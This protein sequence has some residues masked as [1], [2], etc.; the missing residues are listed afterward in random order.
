[1]NLEYA[2]VGHTIVCDPCH[3]SFFYTFI[4]PLNYYKKDKKHLN[5]QKN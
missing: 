5:G 2:F 3:I 1:M 4:T